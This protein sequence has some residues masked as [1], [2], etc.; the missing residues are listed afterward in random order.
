[1]HSK[2]F[3][4]FVIMLITNKL[5]ASELNPDEIVVNTRW[6]T[7]VSL[8]SKCE[9]SEESVTAQLASI[10]AQQEK[11]QRQKASIVCKCSAHTN[12]RPDPSLLAEVTTTSSL[13]PCANVL[14]GA[15]KMESAVSL[16]K[17]TCGATEY[18]QLQQVDKT[19][20][21]FPL[22]SGHTPQDVTTGK[23]KDLC[24]EFLAESTARG[25]SEL[26]AD[27]L[28]NRA[29]SRRREIRHCEVDTNTRQN[30]NTKGGFLQSLRQLCRYFT[31]CV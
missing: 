14:Q 10:K 21:T 25:M 24:E 2:L 13:M 20:I 8:T 22:N 17:K 27:V 18:S 1:M 16:D 3:S 29:G 5:S 9:W 26:T 6:V 19:L 28:I 31:S 7:A 23:P 11:M 12:K 15:D 4:I 30:T